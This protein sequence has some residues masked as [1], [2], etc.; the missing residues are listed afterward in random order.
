LKAN[1]K[2]ITIAGAC[3]GFMGTL[4]GI[5]GP[6]MG[7]VY[8]NSKRGNVVATLNMFFG[9]GALFS[10]IVL[11]SI[12]LLNTVIAIKCL[13]LAPALIMGIIIGRLETIKKFVSSKFKFLILVICAIAASLV[14]MLAFTS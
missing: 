1:N 13:F 11:A 4:T 5:G 3:S 8:Q 2:N 12:N 7:I 14:L 6:P 9:F 10:V